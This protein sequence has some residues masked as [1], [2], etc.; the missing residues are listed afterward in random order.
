MA[1]SQYFAGALSQL[2]PNACVADIAAPTFAGISTLAANSDGT[3]TATWLAATD[4]TAPIRYDVFISTSNVAATLFSAAS[5]VRSTRSLTTKI[6]IDGTGALLVATTYYVGIRARDGIGNVETNTVMIAAAATGVS[7]LTLNNIID[8]TNGVWNAVAT[9]YATA[10]TM[11]FKLNDADATALAI[12]AKLGTPAGASVSAD[13]AALQT[14][15]NTV[16]TKLGTPA[17]ASLSADVAAVKVDT[18]SALTKIGT[19]AGAS[20]S[21]DVAA[22]KAV[23]DVVNAK[24]GTPTAGSVSA[25]IANVQ[26]TDSAISAKIGTPSGASLSADVAAVKTDTASTLT[27]LGNPVGSTFSADI[28]NVQSGVNTTNTKLGTPAGASVSADVAAVKGDTSTLTGRLTATRAT[29]LDNLDASVSLVQ[30]KTIAASQTSAIESDVAGVLTAVQAIQNN[31]DFQGI[32]PAILAIPSSGSAPYKFFA[33]LYNDVGAPVD[34][35]SNVLNYAVAKTDGTVIVAATP[36]TRTGVGLY[37]ASYTVLSTDTNADLV[38]TFT[39]AKASVAFTQ[40]RTTRVSVDDTDIA[41]LLSRLTDQRA[42]NLDNLD[43]VLSTRAVEANEVTR[44]N[45]ILAAEATTQAA[46][47]GVQTKLGTPNASTVSLDIAAVRVSTDKIG[48][49][50]T[51]TIGGDT[52]ALNTKLGV[53]VTSVSADIAAVQ[54]TENT[55]NTKLGTPVSSV[56]ADIAAVQSTDNAISA[57]IG[58]PVTTVSGDIAGVETKLGT[59]AGA[60][61]SAD[62]VAIKS[63]TGTTVSRIGTPTGASLSADVA[64]VQATENTVNCKLGTPVVSVAADIAAVKS[65]T[66]TTISRIGT[67]A[68]VSIA[69]DIAS[70]K[71]DTA[72]V[73]A[74]YTTARAGKLDHLDDDITSREAESV[75]ATRYATL[76]SNDAG[77][78]AA[79]SSIQNNTSFVGIVPTE[80][81]IPDTG[82]VTVRLFANLADGSGVPTDPD[83][84]LLNYR[85]EDDGGG[86]IVATTPMVRDGVG[87]YHADY[88]VLSTDPERPLRV[89]FPYVLAS[90]AEEPVR[91][92]AT[93][94]SQSILDTLAARVDMNVSAGG[95]IAQV[96]AAVWDLSSAAHR[97][98]GTFGALVESPRIISEEITVVVSDD[99]I[100]VVV[101]DSLEVA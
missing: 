31:T 47:A 67:P 10:G 49:P 54:S 35:D 21:A 29:N 76:N 9:S 7:P 69:S 42:Q 11:G 50:F 73:R 18:A 99:E 63:D 77:I 19:P 44:Y 2:V 40:R 85:I 94:R 82:S 36:M 57:K 56:S 15:E 60:S 12:N 97:N 88:T 91:T 81:Q 65:D 74:D 90:V 98:P 1:Y 86:V 96:A 39:Y 13:I 84:N 92:T 68:T 53:P 14:T 61:V 27:K 26:T 45:N 4:L 55:I 78:L 58:T 34:P 100:T 16:N 93:S 52:A 23:E 70:V 41:I 71:A 20:L 32:V 38:V 43:V 62:L 5:Y 24:L 101:E 83:S 28:A 72:G 17:G 3:L 25:D 64:A 59:P 30:T 66:A 8:I 95:T 75:A 80:I 33:N 79:I 6:G 22:V 37:E 89:F 46:V 48:S 87:K 51:G